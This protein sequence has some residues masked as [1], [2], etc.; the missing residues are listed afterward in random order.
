M[1][2]F[3]RDTL[4]QPARYFNNV[5][6]G[7]LFPS[8]RIGSPCTVGVRTPISQCLSMATESS[9][10]LRYRLPHLNNVEDVEKYRSGGF[11][12]VHLG[13]TFKGGKYRVLH[14]LSYGGCSTVWLARDETQNRLV[15]LKVLTADTSRQPTG[16]K[17][18]RHFDKHAQANLWRGNV[19]ATLDDFTIDGP[20]G[21]HLCYVSRPGG[22]S[23]SAISDSPGEIAGTRRLRAPLAG[24]LARQLAEAVFVMH[25]VGIIHGG[26][27]NAGALRVCAD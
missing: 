18:L 23:L 12:P 1:N 21:T 2:H 5:R 27:L 19:T 14:K 15:S 4:A 11:H 20:N 26:T 6:G 3:V 9:N 8:R 10:D 7:H 16:L 22:P 13:D 17:L 25:D 24:K